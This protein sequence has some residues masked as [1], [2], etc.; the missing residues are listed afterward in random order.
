LQR[1]GGQSSY[2]Q[3]FFFLF[4]SLL[5]QITWTPSPDCGNDRVAN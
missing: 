5:F 3:S 2:K 1:D 4:F